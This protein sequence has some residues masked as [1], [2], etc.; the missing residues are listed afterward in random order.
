VAAFASGVV[1]WSHVTYRVSGPT[2]VIVRTR[3]PWI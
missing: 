3:D 1:R 2:D